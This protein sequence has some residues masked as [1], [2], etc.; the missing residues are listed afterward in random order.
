MSDRRVSQNPDGYVPAEVVSVEE[1]PSLID[2]VIEHGTPVP[3]WTGEIA[4]L[5]AALAATLPVLQ[6]VS[7]G[8]SFVD[9]EP[10]PD[11]AARKLLGEICCCPQGPAYEGPVRECL[12]HG[13]G[14]A[15]TS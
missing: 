12:L 15:A 5:R 1:V 6:Y 14:T 8:R 2:Y 9:V 7:N 3:D 13:D 4:R 11:A 10:Y